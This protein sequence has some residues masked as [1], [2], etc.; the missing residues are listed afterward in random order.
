MRCQSNA[1]DARPARAPHGRSTPDKRCEGSIPSRRQRAPPN[2][3]CAPPP[4]HS[5]FITHEHSISARCPCKHGRRTHRNRASHYATERSCRAAQLRRAP[6]G[7]APRKT[8]D[9]ATVR[10]SQDRIVTGRCARADAA[11]PY[12]N[13]RAQ[14]GRRKH[15]R[16]KRTQHQHLSHAHT[17]PELVHDVAHCSKGPEGV[18]AQ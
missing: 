5:C 7:S 11:T 13:A 4:R 15:V 9:E 2:C 8:S 16:P 6:R 18:S 1:D 10:K 3:H 14:R 12:S 17:H